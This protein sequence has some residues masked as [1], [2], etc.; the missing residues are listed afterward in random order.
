ME[1]PDGHFSSMC[2]WQI[3]NKQHWYKFRWFEE[4]RLEEIVRHHSISPDGKSLLPQA[5]GTNDHKWSSNSRASESFVQKGEGNAGKSITS[6]MFH[7]NFFC[8][9]FYEE[10]TTSIL[11]TGRHQVKAD[12]LFIHRQRNGLA[13][14]WNGLKSNANRFCFATSTLLQTTWRWKADRICL[15]KFG[16]LAGLPSLIATTRSRFIPGKKQIFTKKQVHS[17]IFQPF[18]FALDS[19]SFDKIMLRSI[20]SAWMFNYHLSCHRQIWVELI[21]CDCRQERLKHSLSAPVLQLH[22]NIHHR[23]FQRWAHGSCLPRWTWSQPALQ[24]K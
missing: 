18:D 20:L 7:L 11:M 16:L 15:W 2:T 13:T 8:S 10:L 23:K 24:W 22:S 17:L 12:N 5:I 9:R 21:V 4:R 1:H 3:E 6:W 14:R 19:F